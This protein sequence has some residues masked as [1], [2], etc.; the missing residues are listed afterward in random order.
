MLGNTGSL[1]NSNFS[2][3]GVTPGPEGGNDVSLLDGWLRTTTDG[4]YL[5]LSG[6]GNARYLNQT[7][8]RLT[9]LNTD[10]GAV[11]VAAQYRDKNSSWGINLT[12]LGPDCTTGLSYGLRANWCP[13]RRSFDIIDRY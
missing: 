11:Y 7:G 2:Y 9:F 13:Q 4:K 8:T 3:G 1:N 5:W 10:L 6:D 12:G